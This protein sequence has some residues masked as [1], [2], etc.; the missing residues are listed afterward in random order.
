M[1]RFYGGW[2]PCAVGIALI[3]FGHAESGQTADRS[4]AWLIT[5]EEAALPPQA[6]GESLTPGVPSDISREVS[7]LGPVIEVLKPV[8]G[9]TMSSPT[10]IAIRLT[11]KHD[12]IDWG[13]LHV[14]L[15]KLINIDITERVRPFVTSSGIEIPDAQLPSGHHTV[16]IS[17][18]DITGGLTVK[19]ATLIVE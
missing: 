15:V 1:D 18:S 13:T 6:Q 10:E 7:E 3:L 8:A 4:R 9:A 14:W 2:L 17:L 12:P 19:Q 16:R 11:P 5:P